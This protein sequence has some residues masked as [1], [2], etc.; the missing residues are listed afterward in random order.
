MP[1]LHYLSPVV[2]RISVL[3]GDGVRNERIR[4]MGLVPR[5]GQRGAPRGVPVA[6]RLHCCWDSVRRAATYS[7]PQCVH[8]CPR[9][10]PLCRPALPSFP[11]PHE[12]SGTHFPPA[13]LLLSVS[14]EE[15]QPARALGPPVPD[16]WRLKRVL[17]CCFL[18][19]SLSRSSESLRFLPHRSLFHFPTTLSR[20]LFA[21]WFVSSSKQQPCWSGS[22][23]SHG[24]TSRIS[25]ERSLLSQPGGGARRQTARTAFSTAIPSN[26]H[27]D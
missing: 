18:H 12:Q 25:R 16:S 23:L 6:L 14:E 2:C 4:E 1:V 9:N 21:A 27:Q 24:S 8:R 3:S 11:R 10:A 19:S 26:L 15:P 5:A 13:A 17:H 22:A 7:Q 20:G